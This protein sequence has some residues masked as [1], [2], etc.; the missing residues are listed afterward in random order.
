MTGG[1]MQ[2]VHPRRVINLLGGNVKSDEEELRFVNIVVGVYNDGTDI[3]MMI[4]HDTPGAA[5]A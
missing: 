3:C 1:Y 2:R 5:T 4:V